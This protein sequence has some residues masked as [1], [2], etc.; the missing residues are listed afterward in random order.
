MKKSVLKITVLSGVITVS[1]AVLIS[2]GPS[3]EE[4]AYYESKEK[5]LADSIS[6]AIVKTPSVFETHND[7]NRIFVRKADLEFKVKDVKLATFDIEKIVSENK[8]YVTNTILESQTNYKNTVR[9]TKDTVKDVIHFT[10]KNNIT[11]R[12]PNDALDKT[13]SEIASLMDYID[14]RKI[15][16][17]DVTKQIHLAK[18]SENRYS[19]HKKRVE[20]VIAVQGKKLNQT[21]S[22]ENDLLEK[23]QIADD[24]K[25]NTLELLH[26]V[27]YS[28]ININIYQRETSKTESYLFSE[29]QEPYEPSFTEKLGTSLATGAGWF[30]N[31]MLFFVALWPM[32]LIAGVVLLSLKVYQKRFVG[33]N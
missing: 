32:F 23:Q 29:P 30:G 18:L 28:T 17:D 21:V 22:A 6:S 12:V 33:R 25:V 10:V 4:K 16:S 31:V 11:I 7:S 5:Q 14:Y 24:T 19:R 13:L 27:A 26:D 1:S 8:G 2:C 15:S 20:R 3:A 9:V